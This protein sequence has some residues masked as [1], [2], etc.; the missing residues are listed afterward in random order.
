MLQN[1]TSESSNILTVSGL[2][3]EVEK[4]PH[5][6]QTFTR[7]G[8]EY[9][10]SRMSSG[11]FRTDTGA[12]IGDVSHTYEPAQTADVLQPFLMA[13]KEGYMTYRNGRAIDGG[14]RYSLTFDIGGLREIHGE[15]F[16]RQVI[17]GGSHDG[18]WSTF[19]KS[20]I[21]R[22]VCSNGMLGLAKTNSSFRVRHTTNWKTRYDDVLLS[23][24]KT[25][26]YFVQAF[27]TYNRLFDI[28]LT[29]EIRAM[30]TKRLLDMKEGEKASTRKENQFT[31]IMRLSERGRGIRDNTEILNTGAAWYNAV[32]EYVDHYSNRTDAEKRYV[33]AYFGTGETRKVKALELVSAV[34]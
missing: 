9:K 22:Q 8:F 30:L 5:F 23:L 13:A 27:E 32:A 1:R 20:V 12:E 14:R 24:E 17:V 3:F 21:M 2:D 29:R 6:V 11:I 18:S 28:H 7:D 4:R 31:E 15:K 19:I 34:G 10:E 33:S 26:K 16:Q 25:E